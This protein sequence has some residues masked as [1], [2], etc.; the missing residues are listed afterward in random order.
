MTPIDRRQA[1]AAMTALGSLGQAHAQGAKGPAEV[2]VEAFFKRSQL[3]QVA[4]N[5]SGTR[6]AMCV[7]GDDGRRKLVVVELASLSVKTVAALDETDITYCHWVND[8][9]LFF[10]TDDEEEGL[11]PRNLF[12][13]DATGAQLRRLDVYGGLVTQGPQNTEQVLVAR[14]RDTS[15]GAGFLE[16]WRLHTRSGR[17]EQLEVPPWSQHFL[18]DNQG[19]PLAA[20]TAKGETARLLWREGKDWRA[21]RETDRFFGEAF[22]LAGVGPDGTV[23]V[24]ARKGHDQTGLYTYDAKLNKVGAQPLLLLQQ[25]D[26]VPQLVFHQDRLQGVHVLADA[27]TTVWLTDEGKALQAK[28][29]AKLPHTGNVLSL[30]RRG[31]S[32]WVLVWAFSDRQPALALVYHRSSDKLTMLGRSRPQIEAALMS[33]MDYTPYVARDGRRIPA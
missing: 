11:Y 29:D 23:Y 14:V 26:L 7:R 17:T 22:T 27:S 32:P 2:A 3:T 18:I 10:L 20:F 25:F 8:E 6:V 30:P 31:D 9:R 21:V 5:P 4:L 28:V 33:Q 19:E 24:T 13:V 1:L 16:L 15:E 12:A